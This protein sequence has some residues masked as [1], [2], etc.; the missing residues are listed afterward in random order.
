[1]Q[2]LITVTN[3]EP[4]KMINLK[5][6]FEIICL[7]FPGFTDFYIFFFSFTT[8]WNSG[9]KEKC[10]CGRSEMG[11]ILSKITDIKTLLDKVVLFC[12]TAG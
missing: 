6:Y 5:K 11:L 2:V 9:S 8:T 4:I 7:S 12:K 10:E 3:K 1:M